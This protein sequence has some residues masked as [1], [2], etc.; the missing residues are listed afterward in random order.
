MTRSS[1]CLGLGLAAL[2]PL[3]ALA[4]DLDDSLLLDEITASASL[5]PVATNRTGATVE[6]LDRDQ[7]AA[8]GQNLGETLATLPG[9]SFSQNGGLGQT[10]TLRIR[11]LDSGY[12][13]TR[14]NG[15]DFTDPTNLP[16]SL[17]FG[18]LSSG[19]ADRI[20][21]LKGAQ[22]ALYGSNAIAGVVD[23]TTWRPT[24]LGTS[25]QASV[26]AGTYG[27]YSGKLSFGHMSERGEISATLSRVQ[28]DGF[29]TLSGND[30]PDGYDEDVITLNA[31]YD[32][33]DSLRL[34]ISGLYSDGT[35]DYDPTPTGTDPA[36][37]S[38]TTRRGLRAYAHFVLGSV[39]NEL[40]LAR[41]QTE[42]TDHGSFG[43]S[44]WDGSSRTLG[45]L[46]STTLGDRTDL[47]F[48]ADWKQD[49]AIQSGSTDTEISRAAFA[50]LRQAATDAID[51]S[52][53]LRYDDF[54]SF[55]EQ[56]TGRAALAWRIGP[57]LIFRTSLGTGYRVPSLYELYGTSEGDTVGNRGLSPET[58]TSFDIGL[59]KRLSGEGFLKAT[60]F[61]TEIEDKIDWN[62]TPPTG[63]CTSAYGCY[64]NLDGTT[65]SQ[66]FELSGRF[67]LT[68]ATAIYGAYT[69]TDARWKGDRL[70]RVP[71]HDLGLGLS[72]EL[73]PR[74]TAD[75]SYQYLADRLDPGGALPDAGL[76]TARISYTL[77]SGA[78]L[79]ARIENLFNE[80][81]YTALD[82][83]GAYHYNTSGRALYVGLRASF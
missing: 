17:N 62:P 28:T 71:R 8:G 23:I 81:F 51:L 19:L 13:A 6:T 56:M 31:A 67:E 38:D 47:S 26:E 7:I 32:L 64:D 36:I 20:E 48:G 22:S 4:E 27:T 53:S 80:D 33:T 68:P 35:A 58:G 41:T 42:R 12:I 59:E 54:S 34:G 49:K 44:H 18:T 3:H 25:G 50:E 76:G 52:L 16:P 40:S 83:T 82:Y 30:E 10:G 39:E 24:T 14:I 69:Y 72:S 45:Y 75:L 5:T 78:E 29:S 1:F 63:I 55:D 46:G 11:G 43:T 61:F 73:S 9:V 77:D 70:L 2:A 66:G 57:D 65:R 21:V 37:R 15:M 79:Y 74:I 60:A